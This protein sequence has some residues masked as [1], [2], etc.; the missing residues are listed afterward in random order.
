MSAIII[1]ARIGGIEMVFDDE[2]PG[3]HAT[4]EQVEDIAHRLG[5]QA[6]EVYNMLPDPAPAIEDGSE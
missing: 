4:P 3:I 5:R 1:L 2:Q 6:V